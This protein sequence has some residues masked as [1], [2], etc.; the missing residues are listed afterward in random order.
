M[1]LLSDQ[2][3]LRE[4]V[5]DKSESAFAELVRRHVDLVY[6][7][8]LRMVADRHLAKDVTQSVFL[9]LAQNATSLIGRPVIAGWLHRTAQNL[10]AKVVRAEVKRKMREQESAKLDD[11]Y[12]S[13][14]ELRGEERDVLLDAG[15]AELVDRDRDVLLL[16]YFEKKSA[17]EIGLMVGITEE[18]AQRR[19]SRAVEKLRDF[20]E[21]E[22]K[23][24]S[25]A[26]LVCLLLANAAQA[27]PAGLATAI[28]S[29]VVGAMGLSM[30][31]AGV[32]IFSIQYMA[33]S[34]LKPALLTGLLIAGSMVMV[35]QDRETESLRKQNQNM[36]AQI[37]RLEKRR[38][39]LQGEVRKLN[40]E[41]YKNK[42]HLEL[43]Q[44][45]NEVGVMR[46]VE[47]ELNKWR[48][49]EVARLASLK[50]ED[51]TRGQNG[52]DGLRREGQFY[53]RMFKV[54][55]ERFLSDLVRNLPTPVAPST[56]NTIANPSLSQDV[57][58][59]VATNNTPTANFHDLVSNLLKANQV[60][61]EPPK[62]VF[63]N[64]KAGI[65]LVRANLEELEKIQSVLAVYSHP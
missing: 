21:Q 16:R 1:N 55:A 3:L 14:P 63:F 20:F 41:D 60:E 15:L 65:L 53:A 19:V 36:A 2:Q 42:S 61:L 10:A 44:L 57:M 26:G 49:K 28:S 33:T 58:G 54:D 48:E 31:T 27:A 52:A 40:N 12:A 47:E 7:S 32:N 50:R 5:R 9:A 4:Y 37:F 24:I 35:W 39:G 46:G 6:S 11:G 29:S 23:Q 56:S 18:A 17:R 38:A 59:M 51:E 30:G 64:H 8:A 34:L 22:G 13:E 43:L 25:V 62:A 45:R